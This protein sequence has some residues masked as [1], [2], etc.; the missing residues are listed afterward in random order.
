MSSPY[1]V[2]APYMTQI[3][4]VIKGQLRTEVGR[5]ISQAGMGV[6]HS[7]RLTLEALHQYAKK[8]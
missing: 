7:M 6:S 2:P 3:Q 5:T 1:S 8:S 4:V